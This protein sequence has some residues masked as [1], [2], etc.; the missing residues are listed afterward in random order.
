M[1]ATAPK[2]NLADTERLVVHVDLEHAGEG[3]RIIRFVV[4]DDPKGLV[5]ISNAACDFGA[6]GE[7]LKKFAI[8]VHKEDLVRAGLL[9]NVVTLGLDAL[10]LL[11]GDPKAAWGIRHN[12]ESIRI[13]FRRLEQVRSASHPVAN[14]SLICGIIVLRLCQNRVRYQQAQAQ[15]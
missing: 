11:L 3:R 6:A 5:A 8:P 14:V 1:G 13:Q 12:R 4:G 15:P 7:R 10:E 9:W 2:W